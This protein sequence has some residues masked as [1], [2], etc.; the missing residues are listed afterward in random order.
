MATLKQKIAAEQKVRELLEGSEVPLPDEIEYDH[1]CIRL[2]WLKPK[3]VLVVDIDEDPED[4]G[5][6]GWDGPF[7]GLEAVGRDEACEGLVAR[8]WHGLSQ[9]VEMPDCDGSLRS[10]GAGDAD[11]SQRAPTRQGK[12]GLPRT[13]PQEDLTSGTSPP[14]PTDF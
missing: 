6:L 13:K 10:R 12:A 14:P 9:D 4:C 2:F 5:S 3:V 1:T 8:D 11:G 7:E